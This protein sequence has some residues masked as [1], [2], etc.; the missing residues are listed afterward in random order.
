MS[1][2]VDA[3]EINTFV[4]VEILPKNG[5][6]EMSK[7]SSMHRMGIPNLGQPYRA[8]DGQW[9]ADHEETGQRIFCS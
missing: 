8:A 4:F 9:Y 5:R 1:M 7:L 2:F 3:V 6:A